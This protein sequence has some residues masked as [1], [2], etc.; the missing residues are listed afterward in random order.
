MEQTARQV[1]K[2]GDRMGD[3]HEALLKICK[4]CVPD[5]LLTGFVKTAWS[6]DWHVVKVAT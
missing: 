3:L 5:R 2:V 4:L 1:R 6:S